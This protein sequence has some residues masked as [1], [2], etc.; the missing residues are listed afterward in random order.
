MLHLMNNKARAGLGFLTIGAGFYTVKSNFSNYDVKIHKEISD[1]ISNYNPTDAP[2]VVVH[3]INNYTPFKEWNVNS[4]D[5][6][7]ISAIENLKQ[8]TSEVKLNS[9]SYPYNNRVVFTKDNHGNIE[10]HFA[11]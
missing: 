7:I 2:K 4:T 11:D 8:K 3:K 9:D 6:N 10:I 5:K 1:I